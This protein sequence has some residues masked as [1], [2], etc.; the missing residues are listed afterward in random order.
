MSSQEKNWGVSHKYNPD[1]KTQLSC[2]KEL[3]DYT[4]Y[5][6]QKDFFQRG[7]RVWKCSLVIV[8][9]YSLASI[10]TLTRNK[11][12]AQTFLYE[13]IKKRNKFNLRV[14][15]P[16]FQPVMVKLFPDIWG[17]IN[18]CTFLVKYCKLQKTVENYDFFRHETTGRRDWCVHQ[19]QAFELLLFWEKT[20]QLIQISDVLFVHLFV[21]KS[22]N[23]REDI[24]S[25]RIIFLSAVI[26]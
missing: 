16:F 3:Q 13:D 12:W 9:N 19:Q 6:F 5:L 11:K 14:F 21:L 4:S 1:V 7:V 26:E 22:T 25:E 15:F 10:K 20:K 17:P 8:I 23:V 24:G 18:F 2:M